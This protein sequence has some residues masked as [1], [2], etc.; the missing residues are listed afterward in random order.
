MYK[1]LL[2][3]RR[4]KGL[5]YGKFHNHWMEPRS[6]LVLDLHAK[7]G[8]SRYA[9]LHQVRR[10]NL[11]YQGIRFTRS[12]VVTALLSVI[13]GKKV[14]KSQ[15]DR[16]TQREERWDVVEELWYPSREALVEAL[17]SEA[18]VDAARRLVEDHTPFVRRTAVVTAEEFVAAEDPALRSPRI[19]TVFCLRSRPGMTREE[20]LAYWGESHKQLVLSLQRALKYRAYDQLHVRSAAELS[21]VVEKLGGSAGEEFDGVA[22]LAYGSQWELVLGFL[23]PWTQVANLRLVKDEINFIDG[24]RSALV[25]GRQYLLGP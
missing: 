3:H 15:R 21:A 14:P 7:L 4:K 12:P 18:G 23:N 2:C 17:S 24:Q 6:R 5:G 9:Q 1:I 11:L 22:G 16:H 20:M 19:T 10:I 13:Q 25:F 8:Y